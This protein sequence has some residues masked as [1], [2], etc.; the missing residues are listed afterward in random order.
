MPIATNLAIIATLVL[1][2]GNSAYAQLPA[3][4]ELA[5]EAARTAPLK[6][7]PAIAM[8]PALLTTDITDLGI[9]SEALNTRI[10]EY[11]RANNIPLTT[12]A[13]KA[14]GILSVFLFGRRI[15][16]CVGPAGLVMYL[17]L[18]Y[19]ERVQQIRTPKLD[20][21]VPLWDTSDLFKIGE[22]MAKDAVLSLIMGKVKDFSMDYLRANPDLVKH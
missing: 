14:D 9:E 22:G 20:P 8:S 13:E 16:D 1:F 15:V 4:T 17:R 3:K 19:S 21:V 12:G 11:L 6:G 7:K 5:F 10:R 2:A 18:E